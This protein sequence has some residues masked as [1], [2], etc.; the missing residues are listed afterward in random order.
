MTTPALCRLLLWVDDCA[1]LADF[2]T[3]TFGWTISV[4]ERAEQWIELDAGGFC[5]ALH[6]G[7]HGP[8]QRG[9]PKIQVR[10]ADV[11]AFRS[12]LIAR[13]IAMGEIQS[14]KTL[15]WS[16]GADPEGNIFQI[17]NR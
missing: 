9:W 13:G 8:R 14:W 7:R 5:L 10:V 4:D 11:A 3:T 1:A 15:A 2:Y 6:G 12:T 16:E 17:A